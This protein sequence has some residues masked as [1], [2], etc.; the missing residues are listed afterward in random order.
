[1]KLTGLL[2]SYQ[3]SL[4]ELFNVSQVDL[5]ASRPEPASEELQLALVVSPASGHKCDRCWNYYPDD[6]PQAVRQ[7]GPWPNV[8]GRCADALRQMGYSENTQ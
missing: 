7:F 4:K 3:G 6:S 5:G 1:E 2:S 8:C